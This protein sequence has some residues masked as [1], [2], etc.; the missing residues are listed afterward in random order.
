MLHRF[1]SRHTPSRPTLRRV[2]GMAYPLFAGWLVLYVARLFYGEMLTQTG[3]EWSA[4]LDDV[5]IHF[6]FARSTARGYPFQWSEG[7][8]YSSGN[9]SLTY[10]FVLALGYWVGFRDTY[11]MVWA[12]IVACCCVFAFLLVVPRLARGLPPPARFLLPIAVF[13]VGALSWS[14]FSGMEVAWF[15]AVWA[16]ALSLALDHR[17]APSLRQPSLGWKLGLAG[18]LLVTTRP[19]ASTSI[20]VLGCSA[21]V[22]VA[23]SSHSLRPALMTLMRSGLPSLAALLTQAIVNRLLTGEFAAAGALVKLAWYSPYMPPHEKWTTYLFHVQYAFLRNIDYH[24]STVPVLGWIPVALAVIALLSPRTRASAAILLSSAVSFLLLVAMN[25]QVRWQNERYTMPAVAWLLVAAALG[26]GVLLFR[27]RS[28]LPPLTAM[29]RLTLAVAAVVAFAIVQT[30]RTRDQI[31]FFARASRNIRDQHITTGRLLRHH[32]RPPPRR[33]LVGDA[34]AIIYASDLPGLDIIGLGGFKGLPFARASSNGPGAIIELIERI[35][36]EDRPDVFAIYPSWWDVIPIWFGKQ[37]A[38][39]PVEGN[40]ICGGNEK[41]IYAADWRL[42]NS[43]ARPSSLKYGDVIVDQL[44]I[45]DVVDERNHAYQFPHPDAGYVELRIL[46]DPFDD[47]RDALDGGRRIPDGGVERFELTPHLSAPAMRLIVRTAPS[48]P[49][50]VEVAMNGAPIGDLVLEPSE[51]WVEL[52][53]PLP[54]PIEPGQRA[55]FT[56]TARSTPRWVNYHVWLV[57]SP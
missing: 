41:V 18:V 15:L 54:A 16:I 14:L 9:T 13:S 17:R 48:F 56:F 3:G 35:P 20:A 12:A 19:E 8:G 46:T 34:G 10:P 32:M 36:P 5:F 22:F 43:G 55:T 23:R 47:G 30:P 40:V 45:A 42:L 33:V 7:N 52:S 57:A 27:P 25:G 53:L 51:R 6:D 24:F 37:I 11:L 1:L 44:D 50:K 39:V 49:G 4:P 29:P 21:A 31:S 26:L 2:L 28:V 38:T